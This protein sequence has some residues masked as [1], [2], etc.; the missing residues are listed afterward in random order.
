MFNKILNKLKIGSHYRIERFGWIFSL[1]S[2]GMLICLGFAWRAQMNINKIDFKSRAVYAPSFET[3]RTHNSGSVVGVFSNTERTK[4]FVLLKMKNMDELPADA[5][6]YR[7]YITNDSMPGNPRKSDHKPSG[8]IYMF[9]TSGYMGLYII[10]K[11]GFEQAIKKITVRIGKELVTVDSNKIQ[12][13]AVDESFAKY[14]QFNIHINFGADF[15]DKMVQADENSPDEFVNVG[16]KE[17]DVLSGDKIEATKIFKTLVIDP[18]EKDIKAVLLNDLKDMQNKKKLI[19]EYTERYE[20]LDI[21]GKHGIVPEEPIEMRGDEI[22]DVKGVLYLKPS[23]VYP[24]GYDFVWQDRSIEDGYL[25]DV[26]PAGDSALNFMIQ[27]DKAVSETTETKQELWYLNDG[28]LLST[29][30]DNGGT[31][32]KVVSDAMNL[33]DQIVK[34]WADYIGMKKTYQITDLRSFLE[35]EIV[36]QAVDRNYTVNDAVDTLLSY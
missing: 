24:N 25:K 29:Y 10:D 16:L 1:L 34:F 6:D 33:R 19:A 8:S 21:D 11:A 5:K 2:L 36:M 20:K 32:Y 28:S 15:G 14:D 23:Y 26:V 13:D 9:G 17:S 3:S 18:Q 7:M 4:A 31:Q 35:L 30:E 27:H 12:G 22:T